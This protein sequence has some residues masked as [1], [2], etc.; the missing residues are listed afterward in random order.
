MALELVPAPG[1]QFR[2]YSML[3]AIAL[4]S[5]DALLLLIKVFTDVHVISTETALLVN[6]I[7][8]FMLVPLRLLQQYIPLTTEQKMDMIDS[9]SWQPVRDGYRDVQVKVIEVER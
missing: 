2:T 4:G 7:L 9:A 8:T 5:F 1:R 6:G 3:L